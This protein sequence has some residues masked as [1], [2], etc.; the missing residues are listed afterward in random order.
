MPKKNSYITATDQF[1]GAGGSTWGAKEAGVEVKMALNHWDLAIQTHNTNNP[2]VDH[3]CTDVSAC[4]PR[5]YP[6]TDILIT[7][8]ECTNHSLAKGRRRKHQGQYDLFDP[9]KIKPE[10]ERSRATMWDVLRFTEYHDYN[11]IIV[12]NVVDARKWRCFDAWLKGMHD[13][14]YDHKTCYYNSMFFHPCPQS[15]DRMYVVFWKKGNPEPELEFRPRGLCPKCGDVECFRSWKNGRRFGKYKFQYNYCCSNCNEAVTPYYYAA[16]N[17]IDW[18]DPGTR[19]GDRKKP[20][21][22]NTTR[23]IQHGLDK[24]QDMLM[25]INIRHSSGVDCRVKTAHDHPLFTQTGQQDYS[26][27]SPYLVGLEHMT[28]HNDG[29]VRSLDGPAWTQTTTQSNALVLPFIVEMNRTGKGRGVQE[30]LSTV[31]AGGNHHFLVGNYSPGWQRSLDEQLGTI[32]TADH[33]GL[34]N[35]PLIVENFGQSNSK[36]TMDPLGTV[37]TKDKYGLLTPESLK[38][39]L[40]YY[41]GASDLASNIGQAVGTVTTRDRAGIVQ[42]PAPN[43]EDC[44]YRMLRPHEIQS[45]MSFPASYIVLGNN[46]QK[47]RQLGNAVTPPVM[48]WLVERCVDS[49]GRQRKKKRVRA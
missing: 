36:S 8:P 49:L 40:T 5:R 6:S 11:C 20:L 28:R 31:L 26:L 41:Y 21:S 16:F 27:L 42:R 1:C 47:V 48:K 39:F 33:H 30:G 3:D 34:V 23:R 29:R 38:A 15:R 44:Y 9:S 35:L 24:F 12:E 37:M 22:V 14:G 46:R 2:E 17:C 43:I 19:I 4:D 10:E 13:M 18:S 32:T 7:S 45:A 25:L